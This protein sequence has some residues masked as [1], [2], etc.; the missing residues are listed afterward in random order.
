MNGWA[1][2]APASN[3]QGAM[4]MRSVLIDQAAGILKVSRRTIYNWI[5]DGRLATVRTAGG[6]Q[7]VLLESI[8]ALLPADDGAFRGP[9]AGASSTGLSAKYPAP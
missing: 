6:S 2:V 5:R 8:S 9:V 1:G 4:P 3:L 7:R